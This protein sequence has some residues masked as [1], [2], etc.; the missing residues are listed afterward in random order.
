M[1][2]G[3][4]PVRYAKALLEF[5]YEKKCAEQVYA[6]MSAVAGSFEREH[7][8]RRVLDNP[9]L[10][11]DKKT[12][13]I[14]TAG[15]GRTSEV[16]DRFVW[17]VLHNRRERYLQS[18]SLMYLDLY[19][20]LNRISTGRLETAVPVTP[21]TERKIIDLIASETNGKV[22][23]KTSV[24]PELLGGFVFEMDSERLD[25]SIAT[26]YQETIRRKEQTD[27]IVFLISKQRRY[28]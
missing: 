2:T 23:L 16:F 4:I 19:R 15:G 25:A 24:K 22:E 1:N 9:V 5:A 28:V 7:A 10:P 12:E 11:V 8:L 27:C 26:Q 21:E 17:L 3:M 18:I 6:E 14:R 20:K 13:L